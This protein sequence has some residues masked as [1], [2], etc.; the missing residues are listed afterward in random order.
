MSG[1]MT[2]SGFVFSV[3]ET[4]GVISITGSVILRYRINGTIRGV[5]S[6]SR[7]GEWEGC[8]SSVSYNLGVT[9]VG[10][11]ARCKGMDSP[12]EDRNKCG[13]PIVFWCALLPCRGCC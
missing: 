12:R 13:L 3:H 7:A 9:F 11:I 10:Q 2:L 4:L 6:G 1:A 5:G 8:S